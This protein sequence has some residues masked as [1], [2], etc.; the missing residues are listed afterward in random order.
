MHRASLA[1]LTQ[2]PVAAEDFGHTPSG[3]APGGAASAPVPAMATAGR[4][5]NES[6]TGAPESGE[7]GAGV[8]TLASLARDAAALREAVARFEIVD[9]PPAEGSPEAAPTADRLPDDAP[10][11]D[12]LLAAQAREERARDDGIELTRGLARIATRS[13]LLT[14]GFT[15]TMA[16]LLRSLAAGGAADR[17]RER[18]GGSA[19]PVAGVALAA[20]AAVIAALA[21]AQARENGRRIEQVQAALDRSATERAQAQADRSAALDALRRDFAARDSALAAAVRAAAAPPA[22]PPAAVVPPA[23]APAAASPHPAG[24]SSPSR[25]AKRPRTAR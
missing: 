13:A 9:P 15:E 14:A 19:W 8:A 10:L 17:P 24:K 12:A 7:P 23:P 25:A 11:L 4:A 16:P 1:D 6:L 22:P 2:R 21:F 18:S 3:A 5:A 20:A